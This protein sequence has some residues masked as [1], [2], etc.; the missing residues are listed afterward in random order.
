MQKEKNTCAKR[1]VLQ[2][3]RENGKELTF[4]QLVAFAAELQ[5][6]MHVYLKY[7][8]SRSVV[9]RSLSLAAFIL[10]SG[11][12]KATILLLGGIKLHISG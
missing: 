6:F 4:G 5:L 12:R 7:W 3:E 2:N 11:I 1:S 9:V 10:S 8:R